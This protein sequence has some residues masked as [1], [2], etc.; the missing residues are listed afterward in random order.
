[1]KKLFNILK[2]FVQWKSPIWGLVSDKWK[3]IH[4][5]IFLSRL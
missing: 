3:I 4:N 5:P 1:M 2:S